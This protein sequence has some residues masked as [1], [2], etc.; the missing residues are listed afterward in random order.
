MLSMQR[1]LVVFF[2]AV[3]MTLVGGRG[4]VHAQEGSERA[5]R[6]NDGSREGSP[7]EVVDG[8][9]G[10]RGSSALTVEER[11]S[12]LE[13]GFQ[14]SGFLDDDTFRFFWHGGPR[15]ATRDGS[16]EFRLGGRMHNDWA[17][18]SA[19]EDVENQFGEFED[20]VEFRRVRLAAQALLYEHF[21][22]KIQL[23]FADGDADFRE[24]WGALVDVYGVDRLQAGQFKEPF[25]LEELTSSNDIPFI[26]RSLT[27]A[28]TPSYQTGVMVHQTFGEDSIAQAAIGVFR[29]VNDF[30]DGSGDGR[31][32][33][34]ARATAV[35][36]YED[37]GER[38]IHVGGAVSYRNPQMLEFEQ[39]PENHLAQTILNTGEF[40]VQE[41]IRGGIE[42]ATV[43]GP[44]SAQGEFMSSCVNGRAGAG[45][46]SFYGFYAMASYVLTGERRPYDRGRG[47]FK[48]VVPDHPFLTDG[49]GAWEILARY[50]QA[51]LDDEG[52]DG[53]TLHDVTAGLN[54]YWN[55]NFRMMFNYILAMPE[56]FDEVHIGALRFQ[57][58]F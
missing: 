39:R 34:T 29:P 45:D 56:G 24:V 44:F 26:E 30:G 19:P 20:G 28:F 2:G 9:D 18:M 58:D 52:I 31:Y 42:A 32:N 27:S 23:D 1:L 33:V 14:G 21:E 50:S 11:L 55:E 57:F 4:R 5:V 53:G 49:C 7:R 17:F 3:T 35:P 12:V 10:M 13:E 15:A 37:D 54:W 51:D 40:A 38:L 6:R 46:P 8:V 48:S 43:L 25:G 22:F 36:I 41:E 47:V 16:V